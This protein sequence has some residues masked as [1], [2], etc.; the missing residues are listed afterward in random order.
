MLNTKNNINFKIN[1]ISLITPF[2]FTNIRLSYLNIETKKIF[3]KQSYILLTWFY[4]LN[5]INISSKNKNNI[6]IFVLPLYRRKFTLT[7]APMA[8]KN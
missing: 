3:L 5:F 1:F 4:Y 2:I 8:H 6:K 7:K